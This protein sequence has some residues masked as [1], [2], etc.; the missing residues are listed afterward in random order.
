MSRGEQFAK[1]CSVK[2]GDLIKNYVV[3]LLNFLKNMPVFSIVNS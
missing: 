2:I 1:N 3:C